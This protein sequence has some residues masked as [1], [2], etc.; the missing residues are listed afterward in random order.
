MQSNQPEVLQQKLQSLPPTEIIEFERIFLG[1][2]AKA[3]HWDLWAAAYIIEGGCSDD[4]F[5][6]FRAGLIGLG[7]DAYYDAL[8]DPNTLARQ[9]TRGVDFSQEELIYAAVEAYEAVTGE[10]M[11]ELELPSESEPRGTPFD[12]DT[13]AE[14]FPALAER[15]GFA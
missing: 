11:P 10:P 8:R 5:R 14:R 9:P 7:R 4:G 3:N 1:L 6:Y 12:E 2:D 13:V 15:F